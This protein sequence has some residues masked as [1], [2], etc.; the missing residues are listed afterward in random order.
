M[1]QTLDDLLKP[2]KFLDEAVL[3][4]YTKLTQKW[5][6]KGRSRYSLAHAFQLPTIPSDLYFVNSLGHIPKVSLGILLGLELGS[7]ISE[8]STRR[9]VSSDR[10]IVESN[11]PIARFYK[12][13]A[14]VT[15]FPLF[16]SGV[17][18]MA[19]GG[20]DLVGYTRTNNPEY[21][22]DALSEMSLGYTFFGNASSMYVK[23][24]N[25]KLLDKT[26]AWKTAY[27]FV[28]EKISGIVPEP[29]PELVPVK[30]RSVSQK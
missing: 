23:E 18:L 26:P 16:I 13:I 27:D 2:V 8:P 28:K 15:R 4:Q 25:P 17:G 20:L 22:K 11:S 5:E 1:N 30:A 14:D 24:S 29:A 9:D 21:L 7:N 6:S 10:T 19:K 12:K 3:R